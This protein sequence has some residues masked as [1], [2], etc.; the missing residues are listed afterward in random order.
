M[1]GTAGPG[2]ATGSEDFENE[3]Y[4]DML[5]GGGMNGGGMNGGGTGFGMGDPKTA[6]AELSKAVKASG[7]NGGC[8][9]ASE[10]PFNGNRAM[11]A[12]AGEGTGKPQCGANFFEETCVGNSNCKWDDKCQGISGAG[13]CRAKS[14]ND[15]CGNISPMPCHHPPALAC[16]F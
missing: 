10:W 12:A 7:A 4:G 11:C 3:G 1:C 13:L 16:N 5:N 15:S 2:Q 14:D 9:F 8:V 6:C